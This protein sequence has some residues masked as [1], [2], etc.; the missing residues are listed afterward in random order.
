M[1]NHFN[2]F[3]PVVRTFYFLAFLLLGTIGCKKTS[4]SEEVKE[5]THPP[6]DA[7]FTLMPAEQT[8][9]A[10]SNALSEN[11]DYNIYTYEYLYNGCGVA[12]GDVNG[13]GL[14]DLYFSSAFSPNKLYLNL[15]AFK[16]ADVTEA[17]GVAAPEGYKTGVAMADVNGDGLMDLYSCRTSKHDDGKKTDHLFINKGNRDI[18]GMKVPVFEDLSKQMG[19]DD[20]SNTNHACF[21]D[22]DRD[23][24]LDLFL[25]NHRIGFEDATKIK[26]TQNEDGSFTRITTP[27]TPFESNRLYKNENG[28]FTDITAKAAMINSAFGL[29]VTAADI[30]QDGW[31]DLYVANDYIEPDY[32]YINN[33][34]GTFT[35][36]Y[37]EYIRHS[38][39]NSMGADIA[40]INNDG[41]PDIMVL[42]MKAEDPI[43]YKEL[44]HVMQLDRY[45]LLVQY[46]YGRQNGR[47]M[48]QI[49]TGNNSFTD[50]AQYGG[51]ANTDWSWAP[52]LVDFNNDGWR[53][54]YITNGYRKDVTN[55]DYMNF[56]RDSIERSGGLTP[57]RFPDINEFLKYIPSK[58]LSNYFFVNSTSLS[59]INAGKQAG[60]DHPSFS[61]GA[62]YADLDLDGDMDIIVNN[63]D[64]NA[65]IYRNDIQGKN[66]LQ[67]SV[68]G[69]R[70][71]SYGIGTAV[72][73]YTKGKHQYGLLTTNKGFLST[74]EPII[75]FG[76]G[77]DSGID[78]LVVRWPDGS[79]E[80]LNN[81]KSNQRLT[82]QKG[83]GK[84][85]TPVTS[86][87]S[88]S[89]FKPVANAISWKHSED[90]FNDLKREKL[91]PYM[92]SA[93][94]PCISVGDINGDQLEDIF[95]GNGTGFAASL[96]TQTVNGK[97]IKADIPSFVN[98]SVYE[99]CGSVME[100]FDQDGDLD[101]MV[102][103]GGNAF[104]PNDLE[105][106]TRYYV[107]QGKSGLQRVAQFPIIRSNAGAIALVDPD[108]DGFKD[109]IIGGRCIPGSFPKAPKSYYLK[110][111]KGQF[112]DATA[113]SFP[114]LD[115]LGMITDIEA[116][117]INGDGKSEIII[118]GD[119]MPLTVF[120]FDGK[121]WEN[122]T[123][124]FGLEKTDGWWKDVHID[125]IDGDGDMD[126]LA[127]NIGLNHRMKTS[128]EYP[129]TLVYNDFD[130]NGS[131]DP[132]TCYYHQGKMYPFAG[133]DA[134]IS[135]IP[136]LK[137]KFLRYSPY[138]S[139]SI[140][141]IFDRDE[142]KESEYLYT[143]TFQTTY[144]KN[145]GGRFVVAAL[146]YQVQLSPVF[147]MLVKDFNGDGKK[148]ILM[149]G[150]FLYAEPET[151]EMD[152][153]NGTLLF[154]QADGSFKFIPNSA[155][156]FWAM[157]EVRELNFIKLAD[158]R[159]GILTGNNRG[160]MQ[161]HVIENLKPLQ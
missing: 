40:D 63:I 113:N 83:Q 49:N 106:L 3:L 136:R 64:D 104:N 135:Q 138:A 143:Y 16:F 148:D 144:F 101:L 120:S 20:N 34:N 10:F 86:T 109:V 87:T 61:N 159:E 36:R 48:L 149:A 122:K 137:K 42:D 116:A 38:S 125:D 97:F 32:V 139:A 161:L 88:K 77:E 96:F 111:N 123:K 152:A 45:N 98:D 2:Q 11:F 147:D 126:M 25:L 100:D 81:I 31:M 14:P 154:Q 118:A 142:L 79:Y 54:I 114:A 8:G 17:A 140:D 110:N 155:H 70:G 108:G 7:R 134:I 21:F 119:W 128:P 56:F 89:L 99:D 75:H 23:G 146:P 60:M 84:P 33:K 26:V 141:D 71:N 58:K 69:E 85:F 59:F 158:G 19:L 1:P 46:G 112:Q 115:G 107:N 43:R 151:G 53:D 121:Q 41:M 127:G 9:I 30:N 5:E 4:E 131:I 6:V 156:G 65:F 132:I 13:D 37:F 129:I 51:V 76:L 117:D 66:W 80:M 82:L 39:Q 78:T 133:R 62:A 67:V 72:D 47:N 94:G 24:D 35:D 103:S 93:E 160:P 92:M 102:I 90:G 73:I 145:E 157:N 52:L 124:A 15:G 28:K 153:G 18:N 91:M 12:A 50:I 74:S 150:N 68:K 105:Y 29:S 22:M 44:A 95:A 55:L 130:G 27:E 57:Q